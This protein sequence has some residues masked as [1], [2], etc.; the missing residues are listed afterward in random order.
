MKNVFHVVS[1]L[2]AVLLL[3]ITFA[4]CA[5]TTQHGVEIS[6][7]LNVREFYIRNAGSANWGTNTVNKMEDIDKSRFSERVDIR[8]VDTNGVVYCKYNVPFNDTAFTE[9]GVTHPMNT[10]GYVVSLVALLGAVGAMVYLMPA[11]GY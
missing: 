6:N 2:T 10:F 5:S 11:E 8:V 3:G 7:V 4:G 9:T 1:K